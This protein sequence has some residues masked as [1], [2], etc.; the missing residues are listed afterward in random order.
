MCN[1]PE[2]RPGYWT[3]YRHRGSKYHKV[4]R[5]IIAAWQGEHPDVTGPTDL[6]AAGQLLAIDLFSKFKHKL[7][8][9]D[10]T[11]FWRALQYYMPRQEWTTVRIVS[12][13]CPT[14]NKFHLKK[15]HVPTRQGVECSH[16][17]F[18]QF[19]TREPTFWQCSLPD[20][21]PSPCGKS[22][23]DDCRDDAMIQRSM[24]SGNPASSNS[25]INPMS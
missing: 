7:E 16:C 6:V 2:P 22:F 23:C 4:I 20:G 1:P 14:C 25:L 24:S 18:K 11:A 8:G 5:Q 17:G 15:R 21:D 3:L 10:G 13:A 19:R 9:N 12:V